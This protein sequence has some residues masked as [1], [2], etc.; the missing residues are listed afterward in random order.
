MR[1][2]NE[3]ESLKGCSGMVE[4]VIV[5]KQTDLQQCRKS[6]NRSYI[7]FMFFLHK[8]HFKGHHITQRVGQLSAHRSLSS[9]SNLG[10]INLICPSKKYRNYRTLNSTS[11][12]FFSR[13]EI[14]EMTAKSTEDNQTCTV[15]Y[16]C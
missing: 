12:L 5:E 11:S 8:L 13:N 3:M 9:A 2:V 16:H 10:R 15:M 6:R 7:H 14:S 4:K 1:S